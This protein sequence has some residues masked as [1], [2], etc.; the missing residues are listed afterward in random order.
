[1]KLSFPAFCF[2]SLL[3][4]VDD[5]NKAR[6]NLSL[7]SQIKDSRDICSAS[8]FFSTNW[9]WK[10]N[11]I[12]CFHLSCDKHPLVEFCPWNFLRKRNY[13]LSLP[14]MRAHHVNVGISHFD[15]DWRIKELNFWSCSGL[16]AQSLPQGSVAQH[17]LLSPEQWQCRTHRLVAH[18]PCEVP[19]DETL[20]V[21]QVPVDRQLRLP[22][23]LREKYRRKSPPHQNSQS[24]SLDNAKYRVMKV[25][26]EF[27]IF[28]NYTTFK[29]QIHFKVLVGFN[30]LCLSEKKKL[31]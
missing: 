7:D 28:H 24:H 27:Y 19:D 17:H 4:F 10:K 15:G 6:I 23:N 22:G 3:L 8:L 2:V 20:V 12:K 18:C 29:R 26:K 13:S 5:S 31:L 14:T 30:Q 21:S 1:M 11:Q 9:V 25:I 16:K